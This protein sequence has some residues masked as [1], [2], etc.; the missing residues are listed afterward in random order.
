MSDSGEII[1]E[2]KEDNSPM[3]PDDAYTPGI[4]KTPMS[5]YDDEEIRRQQVVARSLYVKDVSPHDCIYERKK[6]LSCK[7]W[8]VFVALIFVSPII[9]CVPCCVSSLNIEYDRCKICLRENH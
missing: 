5:V 8:G 6:K 1:D 3:R 7:G 2:E 9:S 4:V